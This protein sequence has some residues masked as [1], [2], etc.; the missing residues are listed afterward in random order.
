V[1]VAAYPADVFACGHYRVVWPS[2]VVA[3]GGETVTVVP[4]KGATAIVTKE[5]R[6][7]GEV[8]DAFPPEDI[9]VIVLQ[10]PAR[11]RIAQAVPF[12]RA[13][14]VAVVVDV[15]D[16]LPRIHPD[17]PAYRGMHPKHSPDYH[18]DNVAYACEHATLVTVSTPALVPRYGPHGRVRVVRN[19]V[20]KKFL[21]YGRDPGLA[22]V[23]WAGSLHSHPRDLYPAA[24]ALHKL[25][26]EG[27][28]LS[29]VGPKDG[30]HKELNV[31]SGAIRA[32]G[33]LS[34]GDW[35]PAVAERIGVG[36]AP[37]AT[38][39]FNAAKSWLKPLEY[40]A[41]GV[42]CVVSG[43]PEYRLLAESTGAAVVQRRGDWYAELKALLNDDARRKDASEAAREAAS[44]F[45]IEGHAHEW[46]EAWEA[47]LQSEK[48]SQCRTQ[49]P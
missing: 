43:T 18:W 38:S 48:G 29:F 26:K 41:A 47:A 3:M 45:T 35:T 7:T 30:L 13:H 27:V 9:D 19:Y 11:S 34:F 21:G 22:S 24:Y 32:T 39:A 23:G 40:A 5:N 31:P 15:D 1:R 6:E 10:R 33:N 16:D 20:P 36:V 46:A 4:P 2:E 49:S 42:P 25:W 44:A 12:L 28:E 8:V 14:G 17:N 37:L